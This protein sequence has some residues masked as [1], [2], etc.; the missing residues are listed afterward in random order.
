VHAS[1]LPRWRGA[2]P[3]Q[4]AILAGDSE[5]GVTIMQMDEGLDTGAIV[6]QRAQPILPATTAGE[7]HDALAQLGAVLIVAALQ[8]VADGSLTPH[9][10]PGDGVTYAKKLTRDEE[11]IDW[12]RPAND[13][14]RQ[15]RAFAPA[16]GAWFE[17]A[18]ERI[19]VLAAVPAMGNGAP[20][21]VLDATPTIACG[22]GALVPVRLQRAGRAAMSAAD[23]LRGFALPV[24]ATLA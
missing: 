7:L 16:P 23:F 13:I 24:G 15:V 9:P 5:S 10:Q 19:K 21:T 4:R 14:E 3:I 1:L 6:L 20:G 11:R 2:A 8:G 17:H 12:T 18:G 22:I